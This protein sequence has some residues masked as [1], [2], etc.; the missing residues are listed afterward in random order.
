M[1]KHFTGTHDHRMDDKGRVSLPSEFRRVLE[2]VGAPGALYVIPALE[3]PRGLSFLSIP[4]YDALIRRHNEAEYP[5][6]EDEE[7]AEIKLIAHASQIQVDD[8]GRI[9]I[10]KPL[11]ERFDLAKSVRFIGKASRF[12]IW[13]PE[14]RDSY[15]A[16]LAP[17]AG[18]A[19]IRFSLRGLHE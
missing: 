9:V 2:T 11:R 12:E 18:P 7:R 17:E 19:P 3:D 6:F 5:T 13:Q 15:E 14:A 4:G 10:A 8:V 16:E 1:L